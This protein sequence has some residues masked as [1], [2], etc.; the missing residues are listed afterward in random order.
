MPTIY[1]IWNRGS[2]KYDTD[3]LA[4]ASGI[5]DA[6]LATNS[7]IRASLVLLTLGGVERDL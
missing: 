2:I 3:A 1:I 6:S 5:Q 7:L 4:L